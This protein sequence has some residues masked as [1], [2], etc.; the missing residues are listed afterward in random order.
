M[1]S[2]GLP[3][4]E[5]IKRLR[6]YHQGLK[7]PEIAEQ[8]GVT[9]GGIA[10]WRKTHKLPPVR[11]VLLAKSTRPIMSDAEKGYGTDIVSTPAAVAAAVIEQAKRGKIIPWHQ[12]NLKW[13]EPEE[14]LDKSYPNWRDSLYAW[15]TQGAEKCPCQ[16]CVDRGH[17]EI[18][19]KN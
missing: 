3:M 5:H 4:D 1:S 6:L 11:N 17:A 12:Q 7:D 14:F 8:C 9:K 15:P 18:K 16:M 2:H 10:F 19:A 13:Y